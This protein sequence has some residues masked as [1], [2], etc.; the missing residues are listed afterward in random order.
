MEKTR[1]AGAQSIDRAF[2]ILHLIATA[3]SQGIRLK[4]IS[5]RTGLPQ[6]TAHRILAKLQE[7][8]L[9]ERIRGGA[10]YVIGG[11]LT[12]LGLSTGV[13]RFRELAGPTLRELSDEVG[14]A[15][16]LTVRSGLDTVCADRKIGSYPIQV[17]SIEIGSRRP[18]GISANSVAML[19]RMP[20]AEATDIL[21]KNAERL[22][23][24][25]MP[26][27]VL[28]ER[29]AVARQRGYVYISQAIVK[30]SSAIAMPV[31]DV[32]GRPIAAISTIAVLSR[33]SKRRLPSLISL[34]HK[35]A[36]NISELSHQEAVK[37]GSSEKPFPRF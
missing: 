8:G 33:Q 24:F 6:P 21:E 5:G 29:I 20:E 13:R 26:Q 23:P 18:L 25:K 27:A 31:C 2:D 14:D 37:A 12:L 1:L 15:V 30:G 9:I 32:V 16:F 28:Q 10:R 17:L 3:S 34:L 36:E 35:A 19:S 11:E 4:D 7:R 22:S